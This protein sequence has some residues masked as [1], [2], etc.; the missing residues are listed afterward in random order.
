MI[1]PT[2]MSALIT[3]GAVR[4]GA[5]LTAALASCGVNVAI[6]YRSSL[7]AAE[8]LA[9]DCRAKGVN[10]VTMNADLSEPGA[11]ED[12]ARRA[13]EAMGG[14]DILISSASTWESAPFDQ[15]DRAMWDRTLQV[16]L[17][18][19]FFLAQHIGAAM[20]HRGFGRI[21]AIADVGARQP[22]PQRAPHCVSKA[23]LV[24]LTR[25]LSQA[26]APDVLVNAIA[27][28][29]V[30]LD[31]DAG[32]DLEERLAAQTVLGRLGTPGD[33]VDAMLYLVTAEYVTGQVLSVDGGYG[34]RT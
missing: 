26:Y 30:L 8:A 29:P 10:A 19:P 34:E 31:G 23:G 5:A 6:H 11:A 17:T 27:P 4:L 14:V 24:M 25:L 1:D 20:A 18:S 13:E 32:G 21:V 15:V 2:G 33:V 28:G 3:G 7:E 16:N 22:W 12:L 9:S